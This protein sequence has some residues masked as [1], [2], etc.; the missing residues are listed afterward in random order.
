MSFWNKKGFSLLMKNGFTNT[1]IEKDAML[2]RQQQ[3]QTLK[4]QKLLLHKKILSGSKVKY[5][6]P[7]SKC[8]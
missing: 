2:K 1:N 8:N 5:N 3:L 6:L 7:I 4:T